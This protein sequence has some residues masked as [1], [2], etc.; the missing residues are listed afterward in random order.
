[1]S[2]HQ[3]EAYLDKVF[4]FSRRVAA[5]PEGR[6]YPRHPW[7]KV[8]DAVF[9]GAACQF[10][11]LHRIEAECRDGTLSKRI[12]PLSE[13]A[14]GY[15][16]ELQDPG[17]IFALGCD[18]ARRLKR[19]GVLRSDW[20]RGRVVAAA[21]GIEICSSF[22]RCC[23]LCMERR[24]THK[25]GEQLREDIQYYHRIVAVIV[26]SAPF[27]IPLGIRFQKHGETEVACTLALL[28]D[29]NDQLGRR[30]F[31]LLVADA[32]YLQ[33]PFVEAIEKI[34]WEWVINLKDNQPELLAEAEQATAGPPHFQESNEKQELQ[35]WHAP[36]VLWP[37][38][39]RSVR[40]VKTVRTL[41]KN[42][43]PLRP[44]S[45]S[46]KPNAKE[47]FDE[48]GLNFY[49]TNV[50]L[51]LVPPSFIHQLGRSRWTIDADA[52]QTLTTDSHLK[53]PSVH[54][55]RGRAL[56]N[57]TMIRVLAYALTIVFYHRQVRSHFRKPSFGFCDLAR[58]L[59]YLF[60]L[61]PPRMDSS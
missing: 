55:G 12:G 13:D 5:L 30:F 14:I 46:K 25:V 28:K 19:N 26:V 35:L 2:R 3:F 48:R 32:L 21:D 52:F 54:Q 51:G 16:L 44:A 9:L 42:R 56:V 18:M 20:A 29:L 33:T 40:V 37:V 15:A 7:E 34:G 8:F 43:V 17:P 50:E 53:Q 39:D 23:D 47:A 61:L 27:P 11:A 59:A 45:A 22:V 31:D 49:A 41:H 24:V 38:A 57:L 58:K 4:D 6:H 36:E 60:L 1:L 10:P